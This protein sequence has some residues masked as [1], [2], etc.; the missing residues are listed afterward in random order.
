[1]VILA[2]VALGLIIFEALG[3][4][5]FSRIGMPHEFCYLRD[6]KLVWL[7]VC[8]DALI[9]LAYVSISATLSYLV[10]KA[11]KDI[12]FNWV[13]SPL[14]CLSSRAASPISWRCG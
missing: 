7:H 2:T 14:A 12:P 13:F 11:S 3:I 8:S 6:P 9:G 10:Y 4:S 5:V 1:M